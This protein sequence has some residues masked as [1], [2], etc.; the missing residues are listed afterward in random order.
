MIEFKKL[1]NE[2]SA[3][4]TILKEVEESVRD[5]ASVTSYE[6][7]DIREATIIAFKTRVRDCVESW[8]SLED[9]IQENISLI[10]K[11]IKTMFQGYSFSSFAEN[12]FLGTL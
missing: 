8:Q 3:A 6:S 7:V 9:E 12:F 10:S 11:E 5:L 1:A 2:V 4:R